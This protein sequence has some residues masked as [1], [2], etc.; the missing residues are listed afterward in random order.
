MVAEWAP[1]VAN[2]ILE[3]SMLIT[4]PVNALLTVKTRVVIVWFRSTVSVAVVVEESVYKV[5]PV[6]SSSVYPNELEVVVTSVGWS[7]IGV[8]VTVEAKDNELV[9]TFPLPVAP[10]SVMEDKVMTRVV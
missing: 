8:M 3:P 5:V 9:A 2:A 7:F 4:S 1:V 10:L 6:V